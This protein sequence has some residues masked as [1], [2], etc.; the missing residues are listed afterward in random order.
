MKATKDKPYVS[1]YPPLRNW[2]DEHDARCMHQL[3]IGDKENPAAYLELYL[4]NGVEVVVLVHQRGNG[5]NLFT[6]SATGKIYETFA[7]ANA[8]IAAVRGG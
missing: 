6:P 8:R 1:N 3:P 2:L 7:D 4:I 5:W